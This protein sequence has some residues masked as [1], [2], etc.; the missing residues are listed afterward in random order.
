MLRI[1]GM[2]LAPSAGVMKR[3]FLS[4]STKH[5][6]P[7]PVY[8]PIVGG[9]LI[10]V[11]G[12]VKY[13]HD[14]FGGTEGLQRAASFY[15]VAIPKYAEYRYHQYQESPQHVWDDLDKNTAQV[16]LQKMLEL[17]GFYIKSGQLCASN[18][19]NAF[20]KYWQETLSVLTRPMPF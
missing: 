18:M 17:K 4:T 7:I 2:R 10:T 12:G 14:L 1:T 16:A 13:L 6:E 8:I 20:P 9:L 11:A 5:A 3:R 15:S 19:G